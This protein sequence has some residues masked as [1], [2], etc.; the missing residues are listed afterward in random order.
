MVFLFSSLFLTSGYCITLLRASPD[1]LNYRLDLIDRRNAAQQARKWSTSVSSH[2]M[3]PLIR[4][5]DL[6]SMRVF[7][8][9]FASTSK[10]YAHNRYRDQIE[11]P[12]PAAS[13]REG[14]R[15]AAACGLRSSARLV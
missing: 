13:A 3:I 6:R 11:A 7:Q 4:C 1:E 12:D 5:A 15:K 10:V 9:C 8:A 14:G 2:A